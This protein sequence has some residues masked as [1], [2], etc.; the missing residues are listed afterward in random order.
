MSDLDEHDAA[1]AAVATAI[2]TV[3]A[4]GGLLQPY[5]MLVRH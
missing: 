1:L 2:A 5:R 3:A 4:N